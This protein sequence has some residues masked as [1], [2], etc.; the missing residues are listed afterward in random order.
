M[1]PISPAEAC[2]CGMPDWSTMSDREIVTTIN[3]M[4]DDPRI[5]A[6]EAGDP[7]PPPRGYQYAEDY[8]LIPTSS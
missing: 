2:A 6:G 4:K 5:M 8:E 7:P 1:L 3:G